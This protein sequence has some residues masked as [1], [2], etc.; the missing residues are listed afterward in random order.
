MRTEGVLR[1]F[2]IGRRSRARNKGN[3]KKTAAFANNIGAKKGR[4]FQF[5]LFLWVIL[6]AMPHAITQTHHDSC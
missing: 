4:T 1:E 5:D 6:Q 3:I 2:L